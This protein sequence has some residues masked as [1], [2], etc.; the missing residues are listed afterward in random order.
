MKRTTKSCSMY[1]SAN[2]LH[3]SSK[4]IKRRNEGL[5]IELD[6]HCLLSRSCRERTQDESI[7]HTY[8]EAVHSKQAKDLSVDAASIE[9]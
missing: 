2:F 9:V 8:I 5:R 1:L 7:L 6:E 3:L 4:L